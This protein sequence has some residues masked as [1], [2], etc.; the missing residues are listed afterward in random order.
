MDSNTVQLIQAQMNRERQNSQNYLYVASCCENAAYD[1]FAKFFRKQAA[2]E[3]GHAEKFAEFLI[4]KRVLPYYDLLASVTFP[5]DLP[6]L[7][8]T[9]ALL[10]KQTTEHLKELYDSVDDPQVQSYLVWFL[11][12]QVEE[13]NWSQDLADLVSRTDATGWIVLDGEYGDK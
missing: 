7:T 11:V 8:Q 6:S 12:E 3:Q 10:E 5:S 13:E 4:S 1:G 2:E 9:V